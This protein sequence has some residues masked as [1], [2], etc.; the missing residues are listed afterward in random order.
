MKIIGAPAPKLW[1]RRAAIAGLFFLLGFSLAVWAVNIPAVQA[2][3]HASNAVL[4]VLLL[5]MG[6]GSVVG[7]QMA[8]PFV[9]RI[10]SKRVIIWGAAVL[11]VGISLP[12]FATEPIALGMGLFVYGLGNGV[13]EVSVND[14]AV[15]LERTWRRSIM[16]SFHAFF[17]IGSA[18]GASLGALLANLGLSASWAL[19]T[20]SLT[21]AT[22]ACCCIPLLSAGVTRK[23]AAAVAVPDPV[24]DGTRQRRVAALALLA[25]LM[26]LAEGTANDWSALQATERFEIPGGTAAIAYGVFA[27]AVSVGRLAS[28]MVVHATSPKHVVRYGAVLAGV[29]MTAVVLSQDFWLTVA[30]WAV[31]GVGISGMTPTIFSAAG[32]LGG[33]N[34]GVV[35]SRV[36]GSGFVGLLAGPAVIGWVAEFTGLTN[37]L[38][39]PLVFCALTVWLAPYVDSQKPS[40]TGDPHETGNPVSYT[41]AG[42]GRGEESQDDA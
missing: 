28:D 34:Q 24:T 10:G 2:A 29:G 26:M 38:V 14:Q 11:A 1:P 40:R 5:A 31:F 6:S 3:V 17:S 22:L 36:V 27:V 35:I 13:V 4:G 8:G 37:A 42:T 21:A 20:G 33:S 25:F 39:L 7:M 12:G 18:A 32:N 15:R 41:F 23:E 9:D 19:G 30:G 16:G